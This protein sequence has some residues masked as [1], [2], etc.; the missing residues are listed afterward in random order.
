MFNLFYSFIPN[1]IQSKDAVKKRNLFYTILTLV[2]FLNQY[3][4]TFDECN[5]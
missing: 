1:R 4:T 2:T 5:F 3:Q